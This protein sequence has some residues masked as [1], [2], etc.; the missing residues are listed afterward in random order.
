MKFSALVST[1]AVASASA[2][3]DCSTILQWKLYRSGTI[4]DWPIVTNLTYVNTPGF[5]T[6]IKENQCVPAYRTAARDWNIMM[7]TD[8]TFKNEVCCGDTDGVPN[9]FV[10]L[11]AVIRLFK[12]NTTS[13]LWEKVGGPKT[14][15]TELYWPFF[16]NGDDECTPQN[17]TENAALFDVPGSTACNPSIKIYQSPALAVDGRGPLLPGKYRLEGSTNQGCP[18]RPNGQGGVPTGPVLATSVRHFTVSNRC[19]TPF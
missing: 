12:W 14:D 6:R 13:S 1:L 11:C 3:R 15:L 9:D 7:Y 16:L 5:F 19:P 17:W 4:E 2:C 10:D 8:P 18:L